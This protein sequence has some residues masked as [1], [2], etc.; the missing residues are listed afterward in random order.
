[1]RQVQKTF[2]VVGAGVVNALTQLL[3]GVRL[4]PVNVVVT[5]LSKTS[6]TVAFL[7]KVASKTAYLT[8]AAIAAIFD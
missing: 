1:V 7:S 3:A 8:K 4:P 6:P 2:G 5:F